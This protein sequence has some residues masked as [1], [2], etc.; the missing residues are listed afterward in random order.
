MSTIRMIKKDAV[1]NISIGSSFFQK[2]QSILL[3]ITEDKTDEELNQFK[4]LCEKKEEF[5]EP[6]MDHL[7]TMI[8][9]IKEL[10]NSAELNDMIISSSIDDAINQSEN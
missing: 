8:V 7:Y 5:P 6:W 4:S 2:L 1:I 10:E 3:Y 9:I